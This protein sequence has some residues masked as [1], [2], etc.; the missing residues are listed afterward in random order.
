MSKCTRV[1]E[2]A[3]FAFHLSGEMSPGPAR[4]RER[5]GQSGGHSSEKF[6]VQNL[7]T[8]MP[9]NQQTKVPRIMSSVHVRSVT[10]DAASC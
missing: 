3:K 10:L 6:Q 2:L 5:E 8:E 1:K 4:Q 7:Q 9:R